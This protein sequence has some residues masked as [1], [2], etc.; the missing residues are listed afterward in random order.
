M[1]PG[2]VGGNS[3]KQRALFFSLQLPGELNGFVHAYFYRRGSIDLGIVM[4]N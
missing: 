4:S 1:G 2:G 3:T